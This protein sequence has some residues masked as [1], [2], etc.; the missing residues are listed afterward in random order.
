MSIEGLKGYSPPDDLL[1]DRHILVTGS[2]DGIGAALARSCAA[3]GATVILL[4]RTQAKLE[5]VYDQIVDDGSARPG[6]FVMD[7][8]R[9]GPEHYEQ[10][11]GAI[12]EAYGKL[13]GLVHNAGILGD[14]S[15][16]EHYDVATWHR[17]MHVNLTAAF[18]LTRTLFHLLRRSDDASVIFTSSG[19]GRKGKPFWGAYAVSKFGTEGLMQVMASEV[20]GS[21]NIRAN[22]INPGPT[23]T[24]MR[25]A[26][27]PVED[28]NSIR[29]PEQILG[30]YLFLLGPDGREING[31]SLDAQ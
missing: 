31:Q 27:Y 29:T 14:R 22:A 4:G 26:A 12:M 13:D 7:L 1:A 28:A 9:A 6:I 15:P 11:S 10:L 19:V 16:I 24:S 3:H 25:K 18:I 21:T 8:E 17:V 5:K 20:E 30:T 2:G 23:R